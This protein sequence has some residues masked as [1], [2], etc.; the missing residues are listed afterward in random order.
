M[1]VKM[2]SDT[3]DSEVYI[4]APRGHTGIQMDPWIS[5]TWSRRWNSHYPPN[6]M[7]KAKFN[8]FRRSYWFPRPNRKQQPLPYGLKAGHPSANST[9]KKSPRKRPREMSPTGSL[10]DPVNSSSDEETKTPAESH[11]ADL[12][13]QSPHDH[14]KASQP[15]EYVP[16]S[17]VDYPPDDHSDFSEVN[18]NADQETPRNQM[19]SVLKD[20]KQLDGITQMTVPT[21][22]NADKDHFKDIDRQ[23]ELK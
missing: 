17:P 7:T 20:T 12:S 23:A 19:P 1:I 6:K 16:K 9:V 14:E 15:P 8:K 5:A 13:P 3:V 21:D 18:G 22:V 4:K 10:I 2:P 11:P